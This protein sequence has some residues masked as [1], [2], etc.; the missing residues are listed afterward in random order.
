[1]TLR[2]VPTE[3]EFESFV[4]SAWPACARPPSRSSGNQADAEDLLQ[5]VLTRTYA[6]WRVVGRDDP[7]AY[8]RRALLNAYV[9]TWRRRRVLR[10]EPTDRT[11]PEWAR[12]RT[13]RPARTIGSTWRR[14][15]RRCR[16]A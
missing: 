11:C 6:R 2:S 14:C 9:D 10:E 8:V 3:A 5:T 12:P 16:R 13:S 7:V 4:R 15:P 1:M